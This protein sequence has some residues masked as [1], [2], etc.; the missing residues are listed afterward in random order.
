M[1]LNPTGAMD[2]QAAVGSASEGAFNS[3]LERF[4]AAAPGKI[5]ITSGK[6]DSGRQKELWDQA[7]AKY[8]DEA[9]A[10]KWVAP[11]A[12]T[13]MSDGSIATGS[14]HE[15][16]VAADLNYADEA[17]KQWAHENAGNYGLH[18]PLGNEPWHVEISGSRG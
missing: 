9:T 17:T 13:K 12:G 16:G 1:N 5:S 3:Q 8:G 11:P 15:H 10:R 18:F 6:R 14:K 2:P 7:L 4:L